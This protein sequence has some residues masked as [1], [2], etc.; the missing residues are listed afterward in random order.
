MAYYK[1]ISKHVVLGHHPG[2]VF[3]AELKPSQERSLLRS[4]HIEAVVT[5]APPQAPPVPETRE[6]APNTKEA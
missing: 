4:G 6:E 5:E 1:V 2:E 3:E